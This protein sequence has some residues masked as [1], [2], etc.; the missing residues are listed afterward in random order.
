M[1]K[2]FAFGFEIK[3]LED[4]TCHIDIVIR[5]SFF[6]LFFKYMGKVWVRC[7]CGI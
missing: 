2:G 7:C 6:Y 1:I 5:L 3:V 4:K